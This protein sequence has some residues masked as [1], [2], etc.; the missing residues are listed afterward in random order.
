[1][2]PQRGRKFPIKRISSKEF[3]K[4]AIAWIIAI[5]LAEMIRHEFE[6]EHSSIARA[7]IIVPFAVCLQWLIGTG[8]HLYRVGNI[9]GSFEELKVLAVTVLMVGW[10]LVLPVVLV[11]PALGISRGTTTISIPL[12][13][14]MM[15]G[16]R[17]L[18]RTRQEKSVLK[19]QVAE[20]VIVFGAGPLAVHLIDQLLTD[21]DSPMHP[22]AALDD[23]DMNH[24]RYIR[25][26]PVLG[27]LHDLS[28]V[29]NFHDAKVLLIA[30]P[31]MSV[32]L[33]RRVLAAA[34]NAGLDVRV[35]PTLKRAL[36]YTKSAA[37][38]TL[39]NVPVEELIQRKQVETHV[40]DIAGYVSGGRVLV[41]GAGGSIGSELCLQLS[42]FNP[43]ELIMV[44]RDETG[45]QHT[46]LKVRGNGLL[47]TREV[48]LADIRD[49]TAILELFE[50]RRPD[51]VFHAAALKHLPMLEQYPLEAWKTNVLGSRNVLEAAKRVGVSTFVNISTD[52]AANPTSVLGLSK[53]HAEMLTAWYANDTQSTYLSVRFGNVIGSRG[54]MLPTFISLIE[55]RRPLTVTHPEVTRYFMTIPE[56]CQLVIQAGGIG[57]RGEVLI[58]DMGEPIKIMDIVD[59]MVDLSG[60]PVEIVYTGLRNG[61][62][63]HEELVGY[64]ESLARPFHPKIL[65]TRALPLPPHDL[66]VSSWE[67]QV[68][69]RTV[70]VE[71][72]LGATG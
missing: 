8:A 11:G 71:R 38:N 25:T 63:L 22:V 18:A 27:T 64:H 44:D 59:K 24:Y 62:K 13:L 34:E 21:P 49:A 20:P 50:T 70:G 32:E 66:D 1:M 39:R 12:A 45:L 17:Y 72:E 26:V 56:A 60:Q 6:L 69:S 19:Q 51:V 37:S 5:P 47:D 7:F 52:K 3:A 2:S 58:L 23:S 35:F 28:R 46:Q 14:I 10:C 36:F 4:D 33:H 61:E 9:R 53:Q 55:D 48:V 15:A 30:V 29:A 68:G 40:A 16:F 54:S 43:Q 31:D 42:K 41:T 67:L 65:H 57:R